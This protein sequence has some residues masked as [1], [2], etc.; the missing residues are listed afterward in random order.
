MDVDIPVSA[1]WSA[2]MA[3]RPLARQSGP[4]QL[5]HQHRLSQSRSILQSIAAREASGSGVHLKDLASGRTLESLQQ[6]PTSNRQ[7]LSNKS[8]S[9]ILSDSALWKNSSVRED[10]DDLQ[11]TP[12]QQDYFRL[13]LLKHQ[14]Q[15]KQQQYQQQLLLQA[16]LQAQQQ[17]KAM[18]QSSQPQEPTTD[19]ADPFGE[20]DLTKM[21]SAVTGSSEPS[22]ATVA[23]EGSAPVASDAWSLNEALKKNSKAV[24]AKKQSSRPPRALE[25]FNC[26][27]TQTPLWRR[28]LDRKHSLCNACGLYYKQYNGHRPLHVRHK[29]SLIQGPTR[30]ASQPYPLAPSPPSTAHRATLAPK[31]DTPLSPA[32]SSVVS[33]PQSLDN[34]LESVTSPATSVSS[35]EA[36]SSSP[37]MPSSPATSCSDASLDDKQVPASLSI[38]DAGTTDDNQKNSDASGFATSQFSSDVA[39]LLKNARAA[40]RDLSSNG[41]FTPTDLSSTTVS[42]MLMSDGDTFSPTSAACSPMIAADGSPMS[43]YTLPPTATSALAMPGLQAPSMAFATPG[44]MLGQASVSP[45]QA[46]AA[47]AKSLIFDDARFQVLVEHMRPGQM[48]KFLNILEKRCHVLRYRLGMPSIQAS[49]LAHEQ[50]LLSLLQPQSSFP[51]ATSKTETPLAMDMPTAESTSSD[52]WSTLSGTSAFQQN[53]LLASFI[54]SNEA[55]NAF[56]GREMELDDKESGM[57]KTLDYDSHSTLFSSA[58]PSASVTS[59][60]TSGFSLAASDAADSKFW[61]SNSTSVAINANE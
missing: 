59:L 11:P 33:S 49:T 44:P 8:A 19:D 36:Q 60:L 5:L 37:K 20:Y 15:V 35:P 50:Q 53:E 10:D 56:M 30:D 9:S 61:A 28:T 51:A 54:H 1:P 2:S 29:P 47:S 39:L 46:S 52:L 26:K 43:A 17:Q 16:Q 24:K 34:D 18:E 41:M 27:V 13:Q 45:S 48:Y 22:D 14:Q 25:C 31:R 21:S 12:E 38:E 57:Q 42:P 6:S 40:G 32:P 3:T 58:P 55:G 23:K 4:E 7:G